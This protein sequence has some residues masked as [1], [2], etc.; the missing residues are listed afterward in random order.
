MKLNGTLFLLPESLPLFLMSSSSDL[1]LEVISQSQAKV[2]EQ[3]LPVFALCLSGQNES[4]P[5]FLKYKFISL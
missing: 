4:L 3:P 2:K 1:P 5:L